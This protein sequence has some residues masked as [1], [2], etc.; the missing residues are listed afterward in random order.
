MGSYHKI[1]LVGGGTGGHFYPLMSIADALRAEPSS[2]DLYYMGPDPY[3]QRA[4]DA[5]GVT[6]ISC[7]AGK[8]RRYFSLLNYIDIIR[9]GVGVIIAIFR[10]FMLYPDVIVSKGGYTSVPIVTAARFLRI[11]I[12]VHESDAVPGRANT[13]AG[14]FARFI[15]ISYEDARDKFPKDRTALTGIPIR[16]EL[17][18]PPR[19]SAKTFLDLTSNLP[20]ILVLGGS[21]GAERINELILDSLDELLPRYEVIHQTGQAHFDTVSLTADELITDEAY[22][23]RYHAVPFLDAVLLNDA[24]H[25]ASLI[26]SRAGSG[27]IHEIA[28]HGKPAI[29]IPIP[30]SVSHDQRRN[31]Y[32]Y[33]RVSGST[34]LE[35]HNITDGLLVPEIDRIL[36]D[37]ALYT[38]LAEGARKFAITTGAE[39]VARLA[40]KLAAEH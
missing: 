20:L 6:F 24:L 26:V 21:L 12:I 7:P 22:V 5:H 10:L 18:A 30:E 13:Y 25:E 35:E 8:W 23:G 3:D 15:A 28:V 9:T 38:T 27:T 33:A 34:V 19:D 4:L 1:M 11:P 37:I 40:M 14:R 31:A 36:S 17:L 39:D 29:L 2:P 16:K 32:A